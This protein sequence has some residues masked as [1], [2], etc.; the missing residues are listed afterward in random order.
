MTATSSNESFWMTKSSSPMAEIPARMAAQDWAA[1]RPT[2]VA[3]PIAVITLVSFSVTA[4]L[5]RSPRAAPSPQHVVDPFVNR[6]AP[7][8]HQEQLVLVRIHDHRV[9][10]HV[11]AMRR[12][13]L[14]PHRG[15][16]A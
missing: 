3:I 15:E 11:D 10:R 9:E 5:R 2:G 13:V 6:Q 1:V 8:P 16:R 7:P 4:P 12:A 14:H